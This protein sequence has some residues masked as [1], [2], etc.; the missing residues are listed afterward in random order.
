M[1]FLEICQRVNTLS[2]LQGSFSDVSSTKDLQKNIAEGVRQGW[3][4]LQ[5]FRKDWSFMIK[6]LQSFSSTQGQEVYTVAQVFSALPV[7]ERDLGNYRAEGFYYN[8]RPVKKLRIG[9]YPL[10]DNTREGAPSWWIVNPSNN[11]LYINLPDASYTYDIYYKRKVQTLTENTDEPLI[12]EQ[13]HNI[14]IY[15]GLM[16]FAVYVGNSEMYAKND[17]EYKKE[18]GTLLRE[19]I[20]SKDVT[21]RPIV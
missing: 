13:H 2:G 16:N 6:R 19:F 8:N 12:P 11:D 21:Q 9:Q 3:I 17:E 20:P 14:L 1:N 18:L 10:I 7:G 15:L 5:N 4:S